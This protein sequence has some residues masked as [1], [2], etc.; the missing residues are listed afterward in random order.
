MRS[1]RAF[2]LLALVFIVALGVGSCQPAG[3]TGEDSLPRKAASNA[4]PEEAVATLTPDATDPTKGTRSARTPEGDPA[5][6]TTPE[7]ESS[8]TPTEERTAGEQTTGSPPATRAIV[9]DHTSVNDFDSIPENYIR[10]ASQMRMVYVDRS[11]GKN[12]DDALTCLSYAS[13]ASAPNFCS[14]RG[15]PQTEFEVDPNVIEWSRAGGYDRSNWEFEVWSGEGCAQWHEKL[16]CFFGMMEAR[17]DRYD[18][19]SY[20]L[21]YLAVDDGSTIN[22]VPGGYFT[23]NADISDVHDQL[24][25][26][27]E[28]PETIFIYWTTSLARAIGTQE[29]DQFNESMRQFT[30]ENGKVLFDVADILAHDPDGNPCYDNRDGVEYDNGNRSEDHPDDGVNHLAICPHYTTELEGGH[31]GSVAAGKIRVAKAFWV[32]MARLAGWGGV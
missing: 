10:A 2:G 26:E 5:I 30:A 29:S 6:T 17:I 13:P 12:I 31:L 8:P 15:H 24:A 18:V 32:L 25:F 28:H 3:E 21:S 19:V 16:D 1:M 27:S 14:R 20:Q 11:V 9:V 22:D 23:D 4:E 7:I